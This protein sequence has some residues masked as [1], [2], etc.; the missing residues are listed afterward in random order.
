V[1]LFI[2]VCIYLIFKYRENEKR[3]I[4]NIRYSI[5]RDLHDD[6]GSH[7]SQVKMLSEIESLKTGSE[8]NMIITDKLSFIM[9]NMSE[10]VWSINPRYDHFMDIVLRIQEFAIQSLEPLDI[11][12]DFDVEEHH[13]K[14][15]PEARRHYYLIFKEAVNNILKYSKAKKVTFSIKKSGKNIITS[16]ADD[17]IGFD[18]SLIIRGN[19]LKNMNDRATK[20]GGILDIVTGEQGTSISLTIQN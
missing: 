5:A 15:N 11:I 17:G 10:I 1:L 18:P 8:K 3:K 12:L 7:L 19:G 16:I 20:L 2:T 4:E 14:L 13:K 6:M 9:Q